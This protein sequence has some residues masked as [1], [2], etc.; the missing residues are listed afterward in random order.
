VSATG[1]SVAGAG[2]VNGDGLDDVLIGA[3]LYRDRSGRAYVVF[4]RRRPRTVDLATMGRAGITLRG[5]RYK[6]L[7]DNFGREERHPSERLALV[8]ELAGLIPA[9]PEF[10]KAALEALVRLTADDS[11]TVEKAATRAV[12][13]VR[14]APAADAEGSGDKPTV[15]DHAATDSTQPAIQ[16][17]ES[18]F[19]RSSRS[20]SHAS[21][22]QSDPQ[23]RS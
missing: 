6:R 3:P 20:R 14:A 5:K 1:I 9:E 18:L 11:K 16:G 2:D 19:D 22:R 10:A 13:E 7:V 4:G 15:E 21:C 8:D 23:V 17:D 12:K